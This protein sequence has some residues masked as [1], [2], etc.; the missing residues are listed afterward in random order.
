MHNIIQIF[1]ILLTFIFV[2]KCQNIT[3]PD[4]CPANFSIAN[5]FPCNDTTEQI[6]CTILDEQHIWITIA[7]I[8]TYRLLFITGSIPLA[9]SLLGYSIFNIIWE[10]LLHMPEGESFDITFALTILGQV[11]IGILS[12]VILEKHGLISVTRVRD[13]MIEKIVHVENKKIPRTFIRK[14]KIKKERPISKEGTGSILLILILLPFSYLL[15]IFVTL[16]S[17]NT[18]Y[19]YFIVAAI[20]IFIGGGLSTGLLDGIN[21]WCMIFL[22][23][24]SGLVFV[25]FGIAFF[26]NTFFTGFIIAALS[27]VALQIIAVIIFSSTFRIGMVRETS[28]PFIGGNSDEK[29]LLLTSDD[30]NIDDDTDEANFD[31]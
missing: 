9:F 22:H 19:I 1:F 12:L 11:I 8:E 27:S 25:I 4:I 16:V 10:V 7:F 24:I 18:T 26:V 28:L 17:P 14:V 20:Y 31:G 5:T 15:F 13:Y 6:L 29:T 3:C 30:I 21:K 2:I 23:V